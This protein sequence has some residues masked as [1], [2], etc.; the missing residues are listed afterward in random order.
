MS[1]S[2]AAPYPMPSR[3]GEAAL[4]G[5]VSYHPRGAGGST[6]RGLTLLDKAKETKAIR[7]STPDISCL[8][9]HPRSTGQQDLTGLAVISGRLHISVGTLLKKDCSAAK[10]S[11]LLVLMPA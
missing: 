1:L 2:T 10:R 11:D 9:A 8:V 5:C 4:I 7:W 6:P 3:L